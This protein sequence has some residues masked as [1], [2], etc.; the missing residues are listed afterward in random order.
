[1]LALNC[2][3]EEWNVVTLDCVTK[4][5]NVVTLDCETEKMECGYLGLCNIANGM[6]LPCIVKQ[7]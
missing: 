6:W 5:L 7:R 1:M 4:K 2:V 3:T